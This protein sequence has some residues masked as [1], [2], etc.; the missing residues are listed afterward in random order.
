MR[1]ARLLSL[2]FALPLPFAPTIRAQSTPPADPF[3]ALAFLQGTWEAK[4]NR[5]DGVA[6]VGAYSFGPELQ[7]SIWARH[8]TTDTSCRGPASF[9]CAHSDLLY[10]YRDGSPQ[11]LK[12]IYFDNEGHVIHYDVSTPSPDSALFQSDAALPGPQFRLVYELKGQ[13]MS[14]RFQMRLPG[15]SD[16]KS[17]LEWTGGRR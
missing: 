4:A 11:H 1:W 2:L 17:Y 13:V 10:V 14:G 16:W 3:Q 7:N 5:P 12:A 6:V 8:T 15:Q 9:D